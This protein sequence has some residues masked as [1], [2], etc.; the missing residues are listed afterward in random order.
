MEA[1]LPCSFRE[2]KFASGCPAAHLPFQ[3]ALTVGATSARRRQRCGLYSRH[4]RLSTPY[5]QLSFSTETRKPE[6][7]NC[8]LISVVCLGHHRVSAPLP[9]RWA[10]Y[11]DTPFACQQPIMTKSTFFQNSR[12]CSRA[13]SILTPGKPRQ[14]LEMPIAQRQVCGGHNPAKAKFCRIF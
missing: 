11:R 8:F 3:K 12:P 5:F 13:F 7:E 10:G 4:F 2:Q 6:T 14:M 1:E 9:Q